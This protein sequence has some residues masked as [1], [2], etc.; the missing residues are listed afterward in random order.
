M[1]CFFYQT[2]KRSCIMY[3]LPI[4]KSLL[5]FFCFVFLFHKSLQVCLQHHFHAAEMGILKGKKEAE[6]GQEEAKKTKNNRRWCEYSCSFTQKHIQTK[7][8]KYSRENLLDLI[9]LNSILIIVGVGLLGLP[10]RG[11]SDLCTRLTMKSGNNSCWMAASSCTS[12]LKS[13]QSHFP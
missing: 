3:D 10:R 9:K 12:T 6:K 5:V 11:S 4:E 13:C 8:P 7:T 1:F 2:D